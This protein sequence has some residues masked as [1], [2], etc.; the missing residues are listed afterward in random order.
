MTTKKARQRDAPAKG[1][2]PEDGYMTPGDEP[3]EEHGSGYM[4]PEKEPPETEGPGRMRP[5]K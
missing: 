2:K 5:E 1:R 3:P 4:R